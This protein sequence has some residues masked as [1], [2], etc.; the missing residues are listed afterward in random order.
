[1]GNV[2]EFGKL[3]LV[4]LSV[5]LYLI[6]SKSVIELVDHLCLVQRQHDLSVLLEPAC[7]QP[8]SGRCQVGPI[9]KEARVV[10]HVKH[11]QESQAPWIPVRVALPPEH[12]RAAIHRQVDVCIAPVI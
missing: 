1:M 7:V 9:A 11:A 4:R 10:G 3:P 5:A 12:A 6:G 2:V 8:P